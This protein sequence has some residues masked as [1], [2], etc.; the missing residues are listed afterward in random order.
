MADFTALDAI[1]RT[2]TFRQGLA[3]GFDCARAPAPSLSTPALSFGSA[4]ASG[5]YD[6]GDVSGCVFAASPGSQAARVW[7]IV[8]KVL[9]EEE[10]QEARARS[11]RRTPVPHP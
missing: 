11:Q 3:R 9:T 6:S 4:D 5:Q 8:G 2:Q 7:G 1:V 10:E